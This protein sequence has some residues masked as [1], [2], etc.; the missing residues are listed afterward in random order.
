MKV[1]KRNG[2]S[3]P[4]NIDKIMNSLDRTLDGLEG[5][6]TFQIA[7]KTIGGL[8]DG[9]TTREID[10]LSIQ[11]AIGLIPKDPAYSRGAARI[12]SNVIYKEVEGQEVESFSQSIK[13]GFEAGIINE[14]IN[15]FVKTNS[16][17]LNAAAKTGIANDHLFEY[18]GLKTLYDRY[19]QRHPETRE[20]FETP[21]YFFLRVAC[22]LFSDDAK[23]AVDFY[24]LLS[25]HEYMTSSPTLFNSGTNHTQM[26][27]CYLIDSP[28]D[29]LR[30]IYKRKSDMALLSKFAGGIGVDY[31]YVRPEGSLIRG[32][33]GISNGIIPFLH[34]MDRDV[35][36][37]NQGGKRKGAA[38]VYLE[39]WHPDVEAFLELRNNTGDEYQRAH[40]LNIANWVPD[41][42]MR[43][44]DEKLEWTLISPN[45]VGEAG[46]GM[47]LTR[48]YGDDFVELYVK[49]EAELEAMDKK[50][51]WYKKLPA[52]VLYGKMM[53]T[54]CETGNGW[55][56]FKDPSNARSNQVRPDTNHRIRLSNLC[57]EILEVVDVE[58]TAVCNLGSINIGKFVKADGKIDWAKLKKT[59]RQAVIGLDRV[60]DI[61]FY[62][63]P[64][65]ANSNNS[66]RPVG[67]GLMGLQDLFFK[68]RLAFDSEEAK[69]IS[70]KVHAFIYYH[71]MDT[72]ADLAAE[73]GKFENYDDSRIANGEFQFDLWGRTPVEFGGMKWD[74]LRTKVATNGVR[75]SLIIA[76][77]PTATI[78]SIVGAYECIE[79]LVSNLFK[80]ETLSG[81]FVQVNDYLIRE[82]K[83]LGLWNEDMYERIKH[84]EGSIQQ[85]YEIPEELRDMF[86]TAWEHSMKT[87]IDLAVVRGPYICQSH[88]LNLFMENATIGKASSMYMYAWKQG[89]KTTYYLRSRG[90]TKI[91]KTVNASTAPTIQAEPKSYTDEEAIACSLENPEACEACG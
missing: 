25:S 53:K 52:Q 71:A 89:V 16:R 45:F 33:N 14:T 46:T 78:A 1:V 73:H 31:T 81:E 87:L 37:V 44:V 64:E 67:L 79:P 88:S 75:N 8:Y 91:A 39:S 50:P 2:T 17:K 72:S 57:T 43:R 34:S 26:S 20:V 68:L 42:F 13:L 66:W 5:V 82:L 51:R 36:A 85:I 38:A 27:S 83:E 18:F 15:E 84:A 77:A 32:T 59:V 65:A 23:A 30:D 61:N 54:L 24:K 35:V 21:Q 40:N 19:L 48:L 28:Q 63:I 4:A 29:D 62:P 76:L 9:A 22:G 80:R 10:D 86:K 56:N 55:M 69:E 58:N 74:S 7:T 3:E 70:E 60:I 41:E 11:T 49:L 47:D 6:D 12:L 90:A